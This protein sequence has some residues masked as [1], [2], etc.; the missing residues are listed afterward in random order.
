MS[1][2][3]VLT[4]YHFL[5]EKTLVQKLLAEVN[6]GQTQ[7][8]RIHGQAHQMLEKIRAHQSNLKFMDQAVSQ[9]NLNT[10]EGLVVLS[11]VEAYSRIPDK[12]TKDALLQDKLARLEHAERVMAPQSLLYK[13]LGK[14][15]SSARKTI[16]SDASRSSFLKL[17]QK[18]IQAIAQPIVRQSMHQMID[19]IS[20]RFV[21]GSDMAVVLKAL[22]KKSSQIFTYSFDMLGEAAL[23]KDDAA[24]YAQAYQ[25]ALQHLGNADHKAFAKRPNLSIKLSALHP[26]YEYLQEARLV[27]ELLPRLKSLI[28]QAKAYPVDLTVDAEES[29]RL[30]MSLRLF[31]ALYEDP[32]LADWDGFGLAVQA[33]QKRAPAVIDWL[34]QLSKTTGKRIKVRLVKGAY[35][36]SEI[37]WAQERGLPDYPVFTRK[38][39][40]DLAYLVCAQ[41]LLSA[42]SCFYP[43]FATHN[44]HTIAAVLDMAQEQTTDFEF[45]CLYGMG[46]PIYQALVAQDPNWSIPIRIYAP[47]GHHDD[48]LPYLVR[49]LLENGANNSFLNQLRQ[50]EASSETLIADPIEEIQLQSEY[51]HPKI[52]KPLE[53]YEDRR[54]SAGLDL[55]EQ[56]TQVDL[57]AALTKKTQ[58]TAGPLIGGRLVKDAKHA[59]ATLSPIEGSEI[60]M[61]YAATREQL[62]KAVDLAVEAGQQWRQ[63]SVSDR[64]AILNKIADLFEANQVELLRRC[65]LEGGKTLND[66]IAEIREAVDFCR[67]YAVQGHKLMGADQVLPGPTGERNSLRLQ[68]RGVFLCVSPWNFPLA[69]FTG[70]IAAALVTGNTVLAKPATQTSL[71]AAYAVQLMHQAGVP[72]SVLQLLPVPGQQVAELLLPD[73]RIQG[74]CFTGSTQT[75][76]RINQTLAARLGPIV[77]FIAETGG[78]NA[79]IVDSTALPE[80]VVKDVVTSAFQSA[81]QRCSALR[82]LILQEE[83]APRILRML[84][85]AMAELKVGDP[86]QLTTDVG[87]VIDAASQKTLIEYLDILKQQGK[88]LAQSSVDEAVASRGTYVPP[89]AVLIKDFSLLAEEHF[90]PILHIMTYTEQNLEHMIQQV[91]ALG[92]GLTF[93]LQSRIDTKISRVCD[94][95]GA[96]NVYINRNM[97]GAVVGVQPFGGQGLSGTGPKAGGPYYLHRFVQEQ[98]ICINTTAQ[99]GNTTLM[100]LSEV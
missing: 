76:W 92:F 89:T 90:G 95:I 100:T 15:L 86:R 69:I 48:L 51:H 7:R 39:H 26:R 71:I 40:T 32:I 17:L 33:Y 45:Q 59:Q 24:R 41:K 49:R 9:L 18:P 97:I 88:L 75:A 1:V 57:Q 62:L 67:Y 60:G 3:T 12:V 29:D 66:S 14:A 37:K 72:K 56:S 70:Q 34:Q 22:E 2:A 82:L 79:M 10:L 98:T 11:L 80:Q 55:S 21:M 84:E 85:G 43:A 35:W 46:E 44:A 87:P 20:N 50:Q 81:G 68:G 27:E 13:L 52:P 61:V 99:G 28:Q 42:P 47:I 53:L 19:L 65:V 30:E 31:Q 94:L 58:W 23:T 93:G 96:G 4:P 6:L 78:Q 74:V 16:S 63:K 25:T 83:I 36:D 64:S 77:P 5:D 38:R 54:N 91:N 8:Q 73:Q